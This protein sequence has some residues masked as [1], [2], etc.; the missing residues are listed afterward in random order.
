MKTDA[1]TESGNEQREILPASPSPNLQWPI[2]G[3]ECGRHIRERDWAE[4]DLGPIDSWSPALR[5]TISNIVNSPIPKVLTW[6]PKHVMLYNDA[7]IEIVGGYHPAAFGKP[8]EQAW[9]EMWAFNRDVLEKAHRG[10]AVAFRD[11]PF[12]VARHDTPEQVTFDLFY[13]P[14]R[15]AEGTVDG[16][17]C[18]VL[19][20]TQRIAA[21]KALKE[22]EYQL[23][24]VTDALPIL[25]SFIDRDQTY[26]FVNRYYEEWFGLDRKD[27]INRPIREV[28]G[29]EYYQSRRLEIER[30]LTGEPIIREISL[31]CRKGGQR[32][33]EMNYLPRIEADGSVPGFYV[34]SVDMQERVDHRKALERSNRR[35][36]AAIEAAH[37]ILWVTDAQANMVHDQQGWSSWTGQSYAQFAGQ[38]WM[39]AVHPDDR[40]AV[41]EAW[42]QASASREVYVIEHRMRRHDGVYRN[43]LVRGMPILNDDGEIVE[44][45]GIHTD[46]THQRAAEAALREQADHL[47]RQVRHRERAELQLRELNE[48]LEARVIA[49]IAERRATEMKL[50]QAQK[51]ETVGKLTGGVAHDFNNLLQVISGNLQLLS[52]DIAGQLRAEGRVANAMAAVSRGSK[53]ASQLLAFGRR[54]ALEPKVVNVTRFVQGMDD[55]LRRALGESIEIETIYSGGLWNTFID[56]AQIENALLNLAINARDAMDG[57][58]KLTI[59][60]ANTHLDDTY[61]LSH[62]EVEPGQYVMLAVSDTGCGMTPNIIEKVFE[63]FFSTKAEGKGSGLGLSMVYGFVKQSGGHVKIYSEPG[64]G[65]TIRLYLP[66]A[67]ES[68]DIEVVI[69]AAPAT[70]GSETVLVVEDD[71]EVRATVVEMLSDLGYAVLKACDAANALAVI[72]S[73]IPI[74]LLFTDVV[75]PGTMK[76]PELARKACQRLPNLAVLYTS[77]YTENSIVHGGRLDAGVEL[78]SKPYTREAMARK[79]RHVLNNRAQRSKLAPTAPKKFDVPAFPAPLADTGLSRVDPPKESSV[80]LVEDDELIRICTAEIL[81][82]SGYRVVEASNVEEAHAALQANPID[83]LVTDVNLPGHSGKELASAARKLYPNLGIIFATGDTT[84]LAELDVENVRTLSKPYNGEEIVSIIRKTMAGAS[85]TNSEKTARSD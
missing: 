52:K 11:H 57:I 37:G 66:R 16:V 74:D 30:A 29:E 36:Q 59:E 32:M 20:T 75:M 4:T 38:G 68:E 27:I 51:M 78:L 6:G 5:T 7:Y 82:D 76:S 35:F 41:R 56:P 25:I 53:L 64:H 33:V 80:L 81:S 3:G 18:T 40:A 45:V 9:P 22:S 83:V 46:I 48:N 43:F 44:W 79:V 58:G 55:I 12:V 13:T 63:P 54:Q 31:P 15:A 67:M 24:T 62:D 69:D 23:R 21:E 17:M 77:G 42:R 8:A 19:E 65:T 10:Q 28:I 60:L 85:T 39:D 26:R 71:D 49:E 14:I 70:G 2:G 73:G 34:F 50:A 61:A 72:E 47:A 84:G 1:A